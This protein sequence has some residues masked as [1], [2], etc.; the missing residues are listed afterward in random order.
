MPEA[1]GRQFDRAGM[2]DIGKQVSKEIDKNG[3][4]IKATLVEFLRQ[5]PEYQLLASFDR[6][7]RQVKDEP[8]NPYWRQVRQTQIEHE[9]RTKYGINHG[10]DFIAGSPA[11]RELGKRLYHMDDETKPQLSKPIGGKVGLHRAR[12]YLTPFVV[13]ALNEGKD[14]HEKRT[15]KGIYFEN[16]WLGGVAIGYK[17]AAGKDEEDEFWDFAGPAGYLLS[18]R[19]YTGHKDIQHI[20]GLFAGLAI[21]QIFHPGNRNIIEALEDAIETAVEITEDDMRGMLPGGHMTSYPGGIDFLLKAPQAEVIEDGEIPAREWYD[22]T[23][24][25]VFRRNSQFSTRGELLRDQRKIEGVVR[26]YGPDNFRVAARL[27][28]KTLCL[29]PEII[30]GQ[31]D[32]VIELWNHDNETEPFIPGYKLT[33]KDGYGRFGFEVDSN[34]DQYAR[35]NVPVNKQ[36][37]AKL[38]GEYRTLGL[39]TLADKL[40]A[41]SRFVRLPIY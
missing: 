29:N 36:R 12:N 20:S 33:T 37:R 15:L 16:E 2:A 23:W 27:I 28:L 22:R 4:E 25:N 24:E 34:G 5:S 21:E 6:P 40:E 8:L 11:Q 26:K 32:L 1:V 18:E 10:E 31:E 9:V 38:A 30:D 13:E 19:I 39:N 41:Q 3:A 14:E 17:E 7:E 35:C